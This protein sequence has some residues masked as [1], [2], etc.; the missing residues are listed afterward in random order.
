MDTA[1]IAAGDFD[2]ALAAFVE[3]IARVRRDEFS[4]RGWTGPV[5]HFTVESTRGPRYTRV[6]NGGTHGGR[7]VFAF[8]DNRNGDIYYPAGWRGPQKRGKQPV[9]A[10]I[11]DA[12]HGESIVTPFGMRTQR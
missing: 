3:T 1:A 5:H 4:R 7:S 11:Y 10:S 2:A 9:R 6:W 12:D 8:V